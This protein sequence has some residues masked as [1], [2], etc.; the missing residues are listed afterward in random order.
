MKAAGKET[1]VQH[2]G[3]TD[4]SHDENLRRGI[5]VTEIRRGVAGAVTGAF[6]LLV[7]GVPVG[8]A[9]AEKV[10]GEDSVLLDVFKRAPTKETIKQ[11]E[12]DLEEAS[13]VREFVRPRFQTVI[14]Q[15]GHFGNAKGIIGRDGWLFYKPG[16]MSV[17]GP[18]FLDETAHAGR[19]KAALD[20]GEEPPHQDPR[21]AI[22]AMRATLRD[23]G[24]ELVL[25]PVPDKA[26][27]QPA[28]LHGRVDLTRP[29]PVATNLDYAR[30]VNEMRAAGVHVFDA[31]PTTLQAGAPPRYLAQDTH[32]NPGYMQQVAGALAAFVQREIP[33]P[34]PV[35]PPAWKEVATTVSRVGDIVDMLKLPAGQTLFA[36]TTITVNVVQ[37]QQGQPWQPN[38]KSDVLLLG[39]SFANIFSQAPMGWGETAGLG[40]HLALALGREL[41]VIAQNDSGAFATR[42]LLS[43]ALGAGEDRLAGKRVVIWEFASRELAVGDWKPFP[44]VLGKAP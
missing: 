33:L 39:D 13:Y 28:M 30:F 15:Y 44:L 3:P 21:P 20:E 31:V 36:P 32:W 38:D 25:F 8:Q 4:P 2:G 7:V 42:K 9:I 18:G 1:H 43:E 37:D 14:T 35:A 11:Y 22:L 5:I 34:K 19:R 10:Q 29:I 40:P 41:D 24:I 23:R 16:V 12:K 27:M 6:L 26:T 17:A